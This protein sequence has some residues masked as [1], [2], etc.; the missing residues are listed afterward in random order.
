MSQALG[1]N[2]R[3]MYSIVFTLGTILGTVGGALVGPDRRRVPRHAGR[4]GG[5]G[6]RGRR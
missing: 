1:V 6:L 5:R 3:W 2:V 4:A